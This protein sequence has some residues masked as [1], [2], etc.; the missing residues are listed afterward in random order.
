MGMP[1]NVTDGPEQVRMT[2][3]RPGSPCPVHGIGKE[4]RTN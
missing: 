4:C 2:N 1:I 3:F